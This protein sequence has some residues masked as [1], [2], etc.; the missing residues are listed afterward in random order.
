MRAKEYDILRMAV[1]NGVNCGIARFEKH[2]DTSLTIEEVASLR[3]HL[4]REVLGAIGEW[5]SFQDEAEG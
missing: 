4:E 1:E 5:F 3:E 2:R